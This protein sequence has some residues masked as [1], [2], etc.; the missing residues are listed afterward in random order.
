MTGSGVLEFLVVFFAAFGAT[1][2]VI[3]LWFL[4]SK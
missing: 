2:A 4:W 1:Y 3:S